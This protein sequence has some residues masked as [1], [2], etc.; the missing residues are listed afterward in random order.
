MKSNKL[1]DMWEG[2]YRV[3]F[4]F[5]KDGSSITLG[6]PSK[7]SYLKDVYLKIDGVQH[8]PI[9]MSEASGYLSTGMRELVKDK[10][11]GL[12]GGSSNRGYIESKSTAKFSSTYDETFSM[13]QK[14]YSIE[15]IA[16][17][18]SVQKGT[19]INHIEKLAETKPLYHFDYLKPSTVTV[20]AIRNASRGV[21]KGPGYLKTIRENL[22]EMYDYDT[23]RLGLLFV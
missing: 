21:S 22:N 8:E 20:S 16:G 4:N 23:I 19:I 10:V 15:K 17:T 5:Y 9:S 14:R 2:E 7:N 11:K 3:F 18:K 13:I 6:F 12:G 1:F